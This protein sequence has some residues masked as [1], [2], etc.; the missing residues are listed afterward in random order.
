[1]ASQSEI[2]ALINH[3]GNSY[4]A[5]DSEWIKKRIYGHLRK[6]AG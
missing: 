4:E 1:M 5:Y 3:S 2:V 6:E